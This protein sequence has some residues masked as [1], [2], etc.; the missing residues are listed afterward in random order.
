MLLLFHL[1]LDPLDG[2]KL[3]ALADHGKPLRVWRIGAEVIVV[4]LDGFSGAAE[5]VRHDVS[6]Q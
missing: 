5:G 1:P 2:Q 4:D 3:A 6:P